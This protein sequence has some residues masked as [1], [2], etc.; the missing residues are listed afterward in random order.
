MATVV[1]N[2]SGLMSG[3]LQ[4]FLRSNTATTSF[5]PKLGRSWG[6][7]KHEIRIW[8]P[9]ELASSNHLS[10]P[11][12]RLRTPIAGPENRAGSRAS[13][14]GGHEK[15]RIIS[16]DSV[17]S[18]PFRSPARYKPLALDAVEDTRNMPTLSETAAEV[19]SQL[20]SGGQGHTR[21]QSYSLF[22]SDP[23]S[24]R[25]ATVIQSG[26]RS[27]LDSVY[28]I[29]DLA[30]PPA[31]FGGQG[32]GHRRD[33]SVESSA[34]VQIGL[35]ISHRPSPSQESIK[36]LPLP[37]TTY[38]ASPTPAPLSLQIPTQFPSK[39]G[40]ASRSP[41]QRPFLDTNINIPEQSPILSASINKTLPATPKPDISV[42]TSVNEAESTDQI[43]SP[44]VYSREKKL[45]AT[46]HAASPKALTTPQS[47]NLP[48]PS[49]LTSPTQ[50]LVR[51][52]SARLP[53]TRQSKLDWI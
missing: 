51:S 45:V 28:D 29:G 43:L 14:I 23:V 6:R 34:T 53:Q 24:P 9:N 46:P 18:P 40:P 7:Q 39:L 41:R 50:Q 2:L 35:R 12:G 8:G 26:T 21:K 31:I 25:K 36:A 33:S 5:G 49:P 44:A 38:N 10:D 19:S 17:A 37:A 47:A 13:L 20:P 48:R 4:L 52:N 16:M 30:P 42:L 15:G 22:P 1:L 27:D 11:A 3:L 32:V